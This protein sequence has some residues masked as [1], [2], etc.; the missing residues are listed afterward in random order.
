MIK[1]AGYFGSFFFLFFFLLQ[2][3]G[4]NL[5]HWTCKA[6]MLPLGYS[7]SS[8]FFKQSLIVFCCVYAA[9]F[10]QIY[11]CGGV[12]L[13][14]TVIVDNV[15]VLSFLSQKK[16]LWCFFFLSFFIIKKWSIYPDR[17]P[18]VLN[19]TQCIPV[20]YNV[21]LYVYIFMHHL[22]VQW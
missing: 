19:I 2:Y 11:S 5:G 17:F 9:H 10:F 14:P 3:W 1:V 4:L 18:S 21:Y 6:S 22:K 16:D 15:S 13:L 12:C 7:L 8:L 20:F